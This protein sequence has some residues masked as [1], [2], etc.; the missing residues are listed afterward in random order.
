MTGHQSILYVGSSMGNTAFFVMC[1]ERSEYN[2]KVQYMV[3]L[4]PVAYLNYITSAAMLMTPVKDMLD[5]SEDSTRCTRNHHV[6][7]QVNNAMRRKQL[8][9]LQPRKK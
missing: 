6:K 1:S 9:L 2:A 3:A 8:F 5:V 7:G 4:A